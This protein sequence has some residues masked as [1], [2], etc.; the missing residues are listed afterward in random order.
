MTE[1]MYEVPTIIK[2]LTVASFGVLVLLMAVAL[3][4]ALK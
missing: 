2:V 4:L 1:A 3:W